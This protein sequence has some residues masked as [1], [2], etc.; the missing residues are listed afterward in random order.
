MHLDQQANVTTALSDQRALNKNVINHY[1]TTARTTAR[2]NQNQGARASTKTKQQRYN[3]AAMEEWNTLSKTPSTKQLQPKAIRLGKKKP[4]A[5]PT[6]NSP[7]HLK[8]QTK[9]T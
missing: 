7:K 9:G 1:K 2:G 4:V 8:R 6:D 5:S 3:K